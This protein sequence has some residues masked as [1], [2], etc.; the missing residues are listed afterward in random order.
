MW[1]GELTYNYEQRKEETLPPPPPPSGVK[2]FTVSLKVNNSQADKNNHCIVTATVYNPNPADISAL[3]TFS[4][5]NLLEA[6]SK[7]ITVPGRGSR[8]ISTYF[9]VKKAIS[10]QKVTVTTSAGGKATLHGLQLIPF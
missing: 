7:R 3:V 5:S 8:D 10:G 6:I 1:K 4:G 2:E 9:T